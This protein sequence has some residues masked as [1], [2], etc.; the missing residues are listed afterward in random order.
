MYGK[1]CENRCLIFDLDNT[2]YDELDFYLKFI[3][4]LSKNLPISAKAVIKSFKKNKDNINQIRDPIKYI[5]KYGKIYSKE[6][7][8][9][10][11]NILRKF[12]TK[13]SIPPTTKK[14]LT[15][16]KKKL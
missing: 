15:F 3:N 7:H 2:I 13:I 9:K 10:T 11:F 1:E 12:K 8:K 14:I 6:N 4:Y 16:L 5:L